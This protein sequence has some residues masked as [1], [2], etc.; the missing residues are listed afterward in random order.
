[1]LIG[2]LLRVMCMP[3]AARQPQSTYTGGARVPAH[4]CLPRGHRPYDACSPAA[5]PH[6]H[7]HTH[8][9]TLV[10][11]R[12]STDTLGQVAMG[13]TSSTSVPLR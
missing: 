3:M 11:V 5:E 10:S 1:M 12:Y 4:V 8:E 13:V 2:A 6:T 9:H 7:T